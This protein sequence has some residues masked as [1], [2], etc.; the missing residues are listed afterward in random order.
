MFTAYNH[1]DGAREAFFCAWLTEER[2]NYIN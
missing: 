1:T 2:P